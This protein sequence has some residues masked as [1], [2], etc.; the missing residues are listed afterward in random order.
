[1][2]K[3]KRVFFYPAIP[4][5]HFRAGPRRHGGSARNIIPGFLWQI[6][7]RS[8]SSLLFLFSAVLPSD[9]PR[10]KCRENLKKA[11]LCYI[12]IRIAC[13]SKDFF[14]F[15]QKFCFFSVIFLSFRPED[16][17]EPR[18]IR[19]LRRRIPSRSREGDRKWKEFFFRGS[20]PF[21]PAGGEKRH[22]ARHPR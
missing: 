20:L 15:L 22:G 8:S 12:I 3:W 9:L 13:F 11:P 14:S 4:S 6:I 18:G 5:S 10:K 19:H 7:R 2:T 21:S 1:M 17:Q 16:R